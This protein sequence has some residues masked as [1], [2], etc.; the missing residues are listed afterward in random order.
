M[1]PPKADLI[2]RKVKCFVTEQGLE[3]GELN[4]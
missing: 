4:C 1:R 3:G 2:K